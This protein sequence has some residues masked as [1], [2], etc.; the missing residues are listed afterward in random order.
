MTDFKP[1][2]PN[3]AL[4]PTVS[5]VRL[6]FMVLFAVLGI[7]AL[8]VLKNGSAHEKEKQAAAA[9]QAAQQHAAANAK[10]MQAIL[11]HYHGESANAAQQALVARVGA[12][13]AATKTAKTS[14]A[15]LQF[16]LLA[17]ETSLNLF[18]LDNGQVFIT[19]ALVNRM[20]SEGQLAAALAH[21]AAHALAGDVLAPMS[22]ATTTLP[23][24]SYT[25]TAETTADAKAV[26]LMS[27]AGY[28]PSAMIGMFTL[29][30]SAYQ[31]G[32]DV[33]F[34]TTHPN[35]STRMQQLASAIQALYPQGIPK[36]LS[37]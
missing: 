29:L 36:E 30:L 27:E 11:H 26:T 21:G 18:A 24:W 14:K 19:T 7:G 12:A 10:L 32:A 31:A 25:A 17:E 28:S 15:P 2:H 4:A 33:A 1:E 3:L 35:T 16:H 5:R 23:M 9:A 6:V 20:Q 13:I 37:K 8:V 34:F 22:T